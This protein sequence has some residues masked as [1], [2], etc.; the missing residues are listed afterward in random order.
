MDDSI[1]IDNVTEPI[2]YIYTYCIVAV[3]RPSKSYRDDDAFIV[4]FLKFRN[5]NRSAI[6]THMVDFG[7]RTYN[8]SKRIVTSSTITTV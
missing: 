7:K 6:D 8:V 5:S 2:P 4:R 3:S 1:A